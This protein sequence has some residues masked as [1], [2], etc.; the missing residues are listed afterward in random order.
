M[1]NTDKKFEIIKSK[2]NLIIDISLYTT[3]GLENKVV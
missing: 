3:A 2:Y 1:Y